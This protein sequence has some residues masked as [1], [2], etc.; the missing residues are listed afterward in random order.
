[1]VTLSPSHQKNGKAPQKVL[2]LTLR[3][4][5]DLREA[6][7]PHKAAN[8]LTL[9]PEKHFFYNLVKKYAQRVRCNLYRLEKPESVSKLYS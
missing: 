8:S 7:D 4:T 5:D 1:M 2:F 6:P 3:T 9:F